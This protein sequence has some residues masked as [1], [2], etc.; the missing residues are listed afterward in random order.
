MRHNNI[1]AIEDENMVLGER[2]NSASVEF[3]MPDVEAIMEDVD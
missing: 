3:D 1:A 2:F